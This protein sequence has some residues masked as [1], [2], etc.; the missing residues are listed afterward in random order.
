MSYRKVD[1][2]PTS[3]EYSGVSIYQK[4]KPLP[5]PLPCAPCGRGSHA[6]CADEVGDGSTCGCTTCYPLPEAP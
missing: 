5:A 1:P 4:T 3:A 6:F 2:T